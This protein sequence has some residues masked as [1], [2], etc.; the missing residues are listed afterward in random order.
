MHS[1]AQTGQNSNYNKDLF[2]HD[3]MFGMSA[4]FA[5]GNSC[6][7]ILAVNLN[8]FTDHLNCMFNF[9]CILLMKDSFWI[10]KVEERSEIVSYFFIGEVAEEHHDKQ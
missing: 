9:S 7:Q 4:F 10:G 8:I 2:A 1:D 6:E 5:S 3:C